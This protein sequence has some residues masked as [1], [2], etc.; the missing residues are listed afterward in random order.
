MALTAAGLAAHIG[1]TIADADDVNDPGLVEAA[2]L[3]EVASAAVT[4]ELNGATDCPS[5]IQD[6]AIIRIAGHVDLR[7]GYGVV[8][9]TE[10]GDVVNHLAPQAVSSVRQSGAR[11][12]LAPWRK[13]TA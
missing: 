12:L 1:I 6:E 5:A 8:T 11:A 13:R 4:A 10:A 7:V 3:L 9:R 2:R